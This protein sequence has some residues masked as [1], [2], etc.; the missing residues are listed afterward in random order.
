MSLKSFLKQ[1]LN[2]SDDR[3][4]LIERWV[5]K[6]NELLESL[7]E[8][9]ENSDLLRKAQLTENEIRS[10]RAETIKLKKTFNY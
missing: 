8:L 7:D 5:K 9:N 3:V 2:Y 1:N 6:P 10:F 4:T